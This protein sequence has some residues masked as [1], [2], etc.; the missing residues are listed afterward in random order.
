MVTDEER[1]AIK[2]AERE[3]ITRLLTAVQQ[4][5]SEQYFTL[6]MWGIGHD[7]TVEQMA[8]SHGHPFGAKAGT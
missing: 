1:E 6:A 5:F 3:R 2:L 7:K 8:A 4:H